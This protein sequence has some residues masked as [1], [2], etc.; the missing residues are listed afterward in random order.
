MQQELVAKNWR[1]LIRP[2]ALYNGRPVGQ[3]DKSAA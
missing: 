2:R 1:E 3:R